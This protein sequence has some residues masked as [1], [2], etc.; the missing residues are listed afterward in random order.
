MM[1]VG[2]VQSSPKFGEVERNVDIALRRVNRADA[3]LL[4]LPELFNT[5]YR[6]RSAKEALRLAEF[7]PNGETT[8]RLIEAAETNKC[9]IVAGLAERVGKKVYNSSVLVGPKGFIGLYRKAHLFSTEKRLFTPGNIPFKVYDIGKAKVGMMICFD[10]LFP[11]AARSLALKGAD[12]ICHP[13][14]LVLPHCPKAM[15]TRSLENRVFAITANRVGTEARVGKERLSFI[16]KSGIVS[17]TGEVLAR[18]SSTRTAT[19][20]VE[21]DPKSARDK[22]MTPKNDIFKDRRPSIYR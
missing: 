15:I 13:S 19:A 21:I 17:P 8:K 11:E 7:I 4:V 2:F 20:V 5:G 6:F 9:F 16:G 14:N 18:A 10:W 12:I 22:L 1:K 3:D